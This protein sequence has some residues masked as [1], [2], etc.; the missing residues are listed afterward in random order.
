[1]KNQ[2]AGMQSD[3][4]AYQ[5]DE[6]AKS[7]SQLKRE[8]EV[9]QKIGERLI[10]L[11]L[12]KLQHLNLDDQL[13]DAILLAK[14]IKAHEALR[15]QRQFIGKIMRGLS[16][17]DVQS[18]T[19]YLETLDGSNEKHKQLLHFVE[20]WRDKL[21]S[22]ES[23]LSEFIEQYAQVDPS[24]LHQLVRNARKEKEQNKPPKAFR[25]LFT[26]IKNSVLEI[27]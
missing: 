18:I 21:L 23:A 3:Y 10:T 14:K 26:I 1:M 12:D 17:E 2:K 15:R 25:E 6:D 5:D 8:M 19:D 4:G 9:M 7:K 11:P 24:Y 16:E 27:E 13:L 22:Q 20:N